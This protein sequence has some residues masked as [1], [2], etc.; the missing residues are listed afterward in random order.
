MIAAVDV[1]YA[2]DAGYAACLTF[3]RWTDAEPEAE[4]GALVRPVHD[5]E[6][7]HFWRR[8]LPCIVAVLA[9]L[10]R[11][12]DV[13]IVDGYVWLDAASSKGLGAH[14]FD[15]LGAAVPVVGVAKGSFRGSPHAGRVTRGSSSR[16]L[17][18][19]AAGMP[20]TDAAA[21]IG[22]MHGAYRTP[23]LLKRVDQLC[24]RGIAASIESAL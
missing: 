22:S 8:E 12:P 6:P 18:V 14:L 15:A 20:L 3:P 13:V 23:T 1:H 7:G 17:F 4:Y 10:P 16:P 9:L 5:Y 24:R 21:A 11:L 19:T 2:G